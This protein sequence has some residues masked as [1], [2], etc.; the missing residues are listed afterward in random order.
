MLASA[1][2][3]RQREPDDPFVGRRV[4]DFAAHCRS[5]AT[6]R[7]PSRNA[8]AR[9]GWEGRDF[10]RQRVP[11]RI[12]RAK[13]QLS[14]RWRSW[15]FG[16]G[17]YG[18]GVSWI[19]VSISGFGGAPAPLAALLVIIF[20]CS[21]AMFFSL[22]FYVFGRWFNHSTLNLLIAFPATWLISEW[23]RTWL[24]TGFPWLFIGYGDLS[25]WLSGWAPIVGVMGLSLLSAFTASLIAQIIYRPTISR[26]LIAGCIT[27]IVIWVAGFALQTVEWTKVATSPTSIA[28]VQPN[29][30]Q[31]DKWQTDFRDITLD[32]LRTKTEP[33]WGHKI[34]IWPEAAITRVY[35][36]ALPFLNEVNRKAADSE[37]GLITG[38]IYDDQEKDLYYNSVVTFGKAI[39]I[40]HKR[41]LVPFGE[42]VPIEALRNLIEFFNL[43]TSII[44]L[45]PEEQHGLKVDDLKPLIRSFVSV[46]SIF[47]PVC[48]S[49][50]SAVVLNMR[51]C[52]GDIGSS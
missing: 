41:R 37:S 44:S 18:L 6:G 47:D 15:C 31:E 48:T 43:P 26:H 21:M 9:D 25:N 17:M 27:A 1:H 4:P 12:E 28:I 49:K 7:R 14:N 35:S 5:N 46:S 34:I 16:V 51:F 40:H 8:T 50:Y 30:N 23:L 39:G 10:R 33:L 52:S 20:V 38:I 22:P 45:G 32:V 19:Y 3:H 13:P 36:D 2:S 29:I 11:P 42:Y 24:L